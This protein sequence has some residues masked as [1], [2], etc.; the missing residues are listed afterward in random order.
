MERIRGIPGHLEAYLFRVLPDISLSKLV[1]LS[2]FELRTEKTVLSSQFR[3]IC[4]RS[5]HALMGLYLGKGARP[6]NNMS[7]NWTYPAHAAI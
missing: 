6:G 7:D 4:R 5:T 2:H 1:I 3:G